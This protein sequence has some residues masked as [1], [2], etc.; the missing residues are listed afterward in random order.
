VTR[1]LLSGNEAIALGA[2]EAGVALGCGYP[3]TPSTEIIEALHPY[4][5]V[6]TEW[7]VNE[8]VAYEVALGAAVAGGRA[9]VSMKHV[10]V[11][12]AADPL[13]TSAYTGVE[14]GLV[15]VTADDPSMHSSQNEQ[16]NRHYAVAAKIPMFEP[17]DS[18]E[19][20]TLTRAAFELSE[21]F[22]TPVFLRTTTRLSHSKGVVDVDGG[23]TPARHTPELQHKPA[24]YV[25]IPGNARLRRVALEERWTRLLQAVETHPANRVEHGTSS[26]GVITSGVPYTYVKEV[27]PD[28]GVLKLGIVHPLPRRLIEDFANRYGTVYVVEELDPVIET[29][30]RAWG[31]D[32]RGKD[33]F[34]A[35]GEFSPE[36]LRA[37]LGLP[38]H[39]MEAPSLPVPPRRPGLCVG[40]PHAAV[41]NALRARDMIVS[42][43]IGCYSLG[44][45]PPYSAMDTLVDM[46]ASITMA[47][48]M[49]AVLPSGEDRRRVAAVIGDSTFAHSGLT[50]LLN[51]VWNKRDG[52]YIV[53]DNAT[54]AMTGTQPNPLSGERIGREDAPAL[55]YRHLARAFNIPD[56]NVRVIDG[57]DRHE[58]EAAIDD[59]AGRS[60][61]RFLAVIAM[62]VIEAKDLRKLGRYEDKKQR[63]ALLPLA[64]VTGC[65]DG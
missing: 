41:F 64:A 43:D 28:A 63:R 36:V 35:I 15:V 65:C 60:G 31:I 2:W 56:E 12:V 58:I 49:D 22:D 55:D 6:Y 18:A 5:G 62:C 14:A 26:V 19:A 44:V 61:V 50:G 25:M 8:K 7:S 37:A 42:G 20:R 54:T 24:K 32:C 11:N 59:L 53:L 38:Q 34:P 16:D 3:G 39:G 48:G 45:L 21:A 51:A 17:S 57:T 52:L 4:P 40:C 27:L 47:Q 46:G 9:L 23:A 29:Q 10:G 33:V 13:F 30:L 1:R